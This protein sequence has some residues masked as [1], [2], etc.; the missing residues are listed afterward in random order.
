MKIKTS[1]SIYLEMCKETEIW[2]NHQQTIKE[3]NKE[4]K[5][6]WVA[7][8]DINKIIKKNKCKVSSCSGY[9]LVVSVE[10]LEK[11]LKH[12]GKELKEAKEKWIKTK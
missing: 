8:D 5:K 4:S 1:E 12:L 11:E 10:T 9:L 6:K 3:Y 7:V 2:K